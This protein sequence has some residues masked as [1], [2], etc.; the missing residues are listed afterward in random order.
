MSDT[1]R[2]QLVRIAYAHPEHRQDLLPLITASE[3]FLFR[4]W[5]EATAWYL[6][7]EK[8]NQG[9][10]NHSPEFE[11]FKAFLQRFDPPFQTYEEAREWLNTRSKA[12]GGNMR[13]RS[14][15]EYHAVAAHMQALYNERNK[16]DQSKKQD[17]LEKAG[18][19]VGD[20][21]VHHSMGAFLTVVEMKGTIVM[22]K[23]IPYVKVEENPF[24]PRTFIRW[25]PSQ[26]E[27]D[28]SPGG[29]R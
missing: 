25:H 13:F 5:N 18:L 21:V 28:T 24:D 6:K 27:K 15:P 8:K 11:A 23:G 26:W 19:K 20:R 14:T 2:K 9:F 1:L 3:Q 12:Y 10:S 22:R 4:S 17:Q 7:Q 16:S 29:R